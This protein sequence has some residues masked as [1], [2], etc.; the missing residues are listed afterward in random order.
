M[1]L[2]DIY[3]NRQTWAEY[4][5]AHAPVTRSEA[6]SD[7]S[8]RDS[9]ALE[10][11]EAD[12]QA[13]LASGLGVSELQ[14][15]GNPARRIELQ[16]EQLTGGIAQLNADF[17]LLLGDLIWKCELQQERLGSL[18]AEIRLAEF[19]R[20]AR[21]YRQRAERAFLN[22]WYE[23]ALQDFLAAEER[24]YPDYSVHRS[25]AQIYLYHLISLP[26]AYEYFLKAAKYA[27]P[28]DPVQAAEAHFL[29]AMV[30]LLEQKTA[31]AITQ[32]AEAISLNPELA[33]AHYQQACLFALEGRCDDALVRLEAAISGD[34]RYHERAKAEPAFAAMRAQTEA[35]LDRLMQPVRDKLVEV[36]QDAAQLAGYVI[37]QPVEEE[38]AGVLAQVEEQTAGA[39]TYQS[40]LR[41]MT[42]LARVQQELRSIHE[43]FHKQYEIDPRDYVRS[44]AFSSDGLL[45]ASGFLHGGLQAWEVDSG[46]QAWS[47]NAHYASVQSVAFS[48]NNCWLASGG[49]DR[50]I[51]LWEA[52]T[53]HAVQTLKGHT[54]EVRQV[55]FSPDG[56]WLVSASHDQTVRIWR[57]ATGRV[58]E[59]LS[60]HTMPV[61]SAIF[62]PDGSL[63]AS[64]SWDKTIRLWDTL[65]A[66]VV[67]TLTGHTRGVASL[68][69]SPDGRW[70]ASGGEDATVKLWNLTTGQELHTFT[71]HGNSVTSVAFSPNGE[72]LAAGCLGQMVIVWKLAT[73]AVV[74][75][76]KYQNIS[77]NSVAFSPK[78][79][80]LALGSRDLQLWLKAILTEDEYAEVRAGGERALRAAREKEEKMLPA[81]L[82]IQLRQ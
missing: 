57:V 43:H 50:E 1:G 9:V 4:L 73:G 44:V 54:S 35:L 37:A 16:L 49:R 58:A 66:R 63:I 18:L 8:G 24:N 3:H 36:R 39:L 64:G 76:L 69:I 48:P 6:A 27:R 65:T 82:P 75:H 70:L 20:E 79:Q 77:Y 31:E 62:S 80:W 81:Y 15:G 46:L 11:S 45:L 5:S 53:G 71:G 19:E 59:I 72:L 33:E 74:K 23:E 42:A 2:M 47:H 28:A 32:L 21:A 34:A 14:P 56:Q 30:C 10:L 51:R 12:Y 13:A 52:D 41:V 61:T 38:I 25:I 68:A 78:G 67:R 29:A 26:K 22:G 55:A 40:G 60:G 7:E 17:N